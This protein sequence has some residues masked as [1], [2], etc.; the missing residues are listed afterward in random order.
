MI[1][2]EKLVITQ[3]NSFDEYNLFLQKALSLVEKY[4]LNTSH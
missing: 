3:L 2:K 1:A 4:K